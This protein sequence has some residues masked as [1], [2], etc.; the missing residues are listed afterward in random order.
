MHSN[1]MLSCSIKTPQVVDEYLH[2][3]QGGNR[4]T[5]HG[6]MGQLPNRERWV[7]ES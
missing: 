3:E 6:N 1:N 2:T 4:S 5:Q 7:G